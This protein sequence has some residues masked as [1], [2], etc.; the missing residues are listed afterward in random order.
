M[1]CPRS[2]YIASEPKNIKIVTKDPAYHRLCKTAE[3]NDVKHPNLFPYRLRI[4][5]FHQAT[6]N[7]LFES[8]GEIY[9]CSMVKGLDTHGGSNG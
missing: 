1:K 7:L 2:A 8:F 5:G 9:T 6:S 3:L 4:K